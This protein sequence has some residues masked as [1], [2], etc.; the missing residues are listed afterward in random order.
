MHPLAMKLRA[1]GDVLAFIK[2]AAARL[3][4][5]GFALMEVRE[6]LLIYLVG[7]KTLM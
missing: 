7:M 5:L 6:R 3:N 4:L 2:A 1:I